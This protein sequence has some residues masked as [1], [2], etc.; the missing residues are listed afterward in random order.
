L[1]ADLHADIGRRN[2]T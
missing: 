2:V 1:H